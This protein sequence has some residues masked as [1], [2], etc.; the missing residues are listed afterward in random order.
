[1][2]LP[3]ENSSASSVPSE[4]KGSTPD[5]APPKPPAPNNSVRELYIRTRRA[6][7]ELADAMERMAKLSLRLMR[8]DAPEADWRQATRH[9]KPVADEIR[10]L[11]ISPLIRLPAAWR[12]AIRQELDDVE[13]LLF[14]AL[15]KL[16]WERAGENGIKERRLLQAAARA[17][18]ALAELP[19]GLPG[20]GV[21]PPAGP[22]PGVIIPPP[23]PQ[24]VAA[25]LHP[26]TPGEAD[27]AAD[28]TMPWG[29]IGYLL[30]ARRMLTPDGALYKLHLIEENQPVKSGLESRLRLHPGA[31][32][33]LMDCFAPL[34]GIRPQALDQPNAPLVTPPQPR[35]FR[36]IHELLEQVLEIGRALFQRANVDKPSKSLPP[37]GSNAGPTADEL[38]DR[39][40]NRLK[41]A[42]QALQ[43]E[44]QGLENNYGLTGTIERQIFCLLLAGRQI[45]PNSL[46]D[47]Q[48]GMLVAPTPASGTAV[49]PI[50][51][52]MVLSSAITLEDMGGRWLVNLGPLLLDELSSFGFPSKIDDSQLHNW[53]DGSPLDNNL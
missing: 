39:F 46:S 20:P 53:I 38:M 26:A 51:R 27:I 21:A 32:D 5:K 23:P 14:C 15:C 36:D 37:P 33:V 9:I 7:G 48:V 10:Q 47:G 16:W 44:W 1:M 6:A 42:P 25:G 19:M 31:A 50:L 4:G 11:S 13:I 35:G 8:D 24:F 43:I 49:R 52:R 41:L 2:S 45:M 17:L 30:T 3:D 29:R 12:Q 28:I 34:Q 40:L 18:E 22:N